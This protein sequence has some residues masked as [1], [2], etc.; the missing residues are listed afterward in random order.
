[1]AMWTPT[2]L[3]TGDHS[4]RIL[5]WDLLGGELRHT[6][7]LPPPSAAILALQFLPGPSLSHPFLL[8]CCGWFSKICPFISQNDTPFSAT[9][10]DY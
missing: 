6:L 2:T 9:S 3:A 8:S 7:Q 1:M 5:L 4:G 10:L